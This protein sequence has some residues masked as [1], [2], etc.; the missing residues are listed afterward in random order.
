MR[1]PPWVLYL[2]PCL[3]LGVFFQG[4]FYAWFFMDDFAWLGLLQQT[5]DV[6]S[7]LENLFWP[8][9]QG[10]IRFL[11]DRLYFLLLTWLFGF[12][13]LPFRIVAFGVHCYSLILLNR[14]TGKLTASRMAGF[15]AA[16]FWAMLPWVAV[17]LS[18]AAAFNQI[19]VGALVLTAF[20]WLLRYLESNNWRHLAAQWAAYLAAF[21]ALE[22]VI[23]YPA[24]ATLYTYLYRRD[25][26]RSTVAMWIPAAAFT[27][28][29][30]YW[31]PRPEGAAYHTSYSWGAVTNLMHYSWLAIGPTQL[32]RFTGLE[33]QR[34]GEAVGAVSALLIVG[35]VVYRAWIRRDLLPAFFAAWF[36]LLLAPVLPLLNHVSEYYLV[37]PSSGLAMLAG[38][39][40][41]HV[42]RSRMALRTI[43]L[44][45][46][47][48][49]SAG[50][51]FGAVA[52]TD[53][54]AEHSNR[55]REVILAVESAYKD[56]KAPVVLLAG[57]DT[58]L[59]Q[60]GFQDIPFRVW[61]VPHVYLVPGSETAIRTREELRALEIYKTTLD[62]AVELL[63]D[64]QVAVLTVTNAGILD[65]TDRYR[66]I[67]LNQYVQHAATR[68]IDAGDRQFSSHLGDGWYDVEGDAR[69]MSRKAAVRLAS[70]D[71]TSD[72]LHIHGFL[73]AS[74]A[75]TGPLNLNVLVNGSSVGKAALTRA[76]QPF[77]LSFRLPESLAGGPPVLVEME[78]DRT[79]RVPGDKRDLGVIF[80][81][82]AIRP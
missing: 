82:L 35:F 65:S 64:R 1:I 40:L 80:G 68:W 74:I 13:A 24:I 7:L 71:S 54:Y 41:V 63:H 45:T 4:S 20:W 29:H 6:K 81:T 17:A 22:S 31:I 18:W 8:Q 48:T 69:W 51:W 50:S 79:T 2:L 19:L 23:V 62:R 12:E 72:K 53:W 43:A 59:F 70:P 42:F 75:E 5:R 14:L 67:A 11:S 28:A 60:S 49:Y 61:G 30:L 57:V 10:T 26:V 3:L 25:K 58:D 44:A 76:G 32:G 37:A 46:V 52:L 16:C 55:V 47:I 78:L 39:G 73:P 56:R 9:A 21:G 36:V 38:Y 66:T 15:A 34:A 77:E 33:W 27:L